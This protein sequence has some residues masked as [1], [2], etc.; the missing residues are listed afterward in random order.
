MTTFTMLPNDLVLNCLARVSR[1]YYPTLSIV[2]K[3]FPS[4]LA[5]VELYQTRDLLDR[6]ESCLYVCLGL[7]S[8]YGRQRWF[9]LCRRPNSSKKVLVPIT[10]P[11]SPTYQTD[12]AR[13]GSK[14]YAIGGHI[15]NND[16]N[17]SPS[18]MV[19]DC[20]SHTWSNAPS[21]FVARGAP[22]VCVLDGKIH[23]FGGCKNLDAT[24]WME[25][26]DTNTQTWEFAPSSSL[27]EKICSSFRYQS[28]AY[29]GN[30]YVNPFGKPE[31]FYKMVNKGRWRA[32]DLALAQPWICLSPYCVMENVLYSYLY[33]R[34][35]WYDSQ[36]KCWKEVEGLESL[37]SIPRYT[38]KLADY[39]G[40]LAVLWDDNACGQSGPPY[41]A[42]TLNE[43]QPDTNIFCAEISLEKRQ[44]GTIW[45][46]LEYLDV[47][48]TTNEPYIVAHVVAATI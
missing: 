16:D 36:V 24:N 41:N 35:R 18:V 5:S 10:S 38:S 46:T 27:D 37:F 43:C 31:I 19:M 26:F 14:I 42:R 4:L 22:S 7:A 23:V 32:G 45:G 17:A 28:F 13:V 25:V 34:I 30:V 44:G 33:G 9:T 8:Y 29:D 12:F 2:S 48:Y 3:R 40:K 15:N 21:M 6:T 39:G 1:L 11:D 47:V 20:R